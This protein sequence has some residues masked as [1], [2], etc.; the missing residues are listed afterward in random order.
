MISPVEVL[1]VRPAGSTGVMDHEAT[2]PPLAVG[3][4]GVMLVPFSAVRELGLNVMPDGGATSTS[5]VMVA[6]ALP[7]VLL[8]VT[9]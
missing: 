7:P 4:T 2:G 6:V 1:K 9:V 3:T 8:A 5:T